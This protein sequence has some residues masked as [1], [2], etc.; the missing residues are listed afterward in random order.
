MHRALIISLMLGQLIGA[1]TITCSADCFTKIAG[2]STVLL[3][4]D[5]AVSGSQKAVAVA[6]HPFRPRA[7]LARL[8]R[9]KATK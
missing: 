4:A 2:A 6:T 5:K 9:K 8:K 7:A 1:G 3:N